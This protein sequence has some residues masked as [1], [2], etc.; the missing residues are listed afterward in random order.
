[1]RNDVS[2]RKTKLFFENKAPYT[3]VTVRE[4]KYVPHYISLQNVSYVV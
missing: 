4:Y 3:C 2:L 1:M